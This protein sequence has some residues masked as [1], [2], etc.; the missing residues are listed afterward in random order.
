MKQLSDIDFI[1]FCYEQVLNRPAD[2][3]GKAAYLHELEHKRTTREAILLKF[4]TCPEYELLKSTREFVP[5]GHFY[6]AVPSFDTRTAFLQA[7]DLLVDQLPGIDINDTQQQT[8]MQNLKP[9]YDDCPFPEDKTDGAR[10]YFNNPAYAH[11]D[12]LILHSMMR[13]VKPNRIIEIGSGF[14]S[15]A[16]LDTNDEF[17]N[18]EIEFT[19]IEPYPELLYSLMKSEDT[20]LVIGDPAQS[21]ST[22]LFTSLHEN[23]ILFIDSTH[24]S[25]LNSDV[26]HIIFNVLPSLKSGVYVHFHDIFWPFEYPKSWVS[27]GR[28]WNEAYMLRA[29]LQYNNEFDLVFLSSYMH[30]HHQAWISEHMPRMRNNM[31]GNLWLRKK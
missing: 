24:V 8:L 19:F 30:L 3:S 6:S 31:G 1:E 21:L 26:N 29:F 4:L 22:E 18:G 15:C 12:A 14:S 25:K 9:Y 16:M 28:A 10:Y 27:E 11:T 17:F 13:H 23:D 2:S 5:T 7:P 20:H